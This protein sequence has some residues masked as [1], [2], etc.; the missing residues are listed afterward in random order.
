[1]NEMLEVWVVLTTTY[2]YKLTDCK[3]S[4]TSAV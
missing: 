4:K 3:K 1:M 2:Q